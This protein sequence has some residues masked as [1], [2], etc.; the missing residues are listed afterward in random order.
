MESK[1]KSQDIPILL[2]VL[3]LG[4]Q[5]K[6]EELEKALSISKSALHRSLQRCSNA[7]L[8]AESQTQ[9]FTDNVLEFLVHG[10]KFVFAANAGKLTRGVATAHSAAPLNK[11]IVA[12]KDVFVWPSIKGS[13]KGQ[14]I[15]PLHT[16]VPEIAVKNIP[17]YE[18]LALIDAIRVGKPREINIAVKLLTELINKYGK[19]F[20]Q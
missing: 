6:Y 10:V 14:A 4:K 19:T 8:I 5:W 17:L 16:V 15:E 12:K 2:Q 13:I 11:H 9:I 3:L 18:M 7:K 1:I 20:N